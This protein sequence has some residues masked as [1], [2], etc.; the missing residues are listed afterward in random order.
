MSGNI[1]FMWNGQWRRRRIDSVVV[2]TPDGRMKKSKAE[3]ELILLAGPDR[4]LLRVTP[5]R[6]SSTLHWGIVSLLAG[7][8]TVRAFDLLM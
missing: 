2:I 7:L 1:Q 3:G 5:E 6:G 4:P 8:I